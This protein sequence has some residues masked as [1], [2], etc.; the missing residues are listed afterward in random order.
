[1]SGTVI[2][3]NINVAGLALNNHV[4][5]VADQETDDFGS[6]NT[7]FDGLMGLAKSALSEEQTLTPP[8]SLAQQGLIQQAI[9]SYKIPRLADNLKDGEITFGYVLPL[10]SYIYF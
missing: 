9:V 3:D 2:Q 7:P 6:N 8:E 1:V 5:G 10:M 4:F